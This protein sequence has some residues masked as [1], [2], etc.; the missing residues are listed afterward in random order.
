MFHFFT[1]VIHKLESLSAFLLFFFLHFFFFLVVNIYHFSE[2]FTH[3]QRNLEQVSNKVPNYVK[4][5]TKHFLWRLWKNEKMV[6][7]YITFAL[8]AFA[9]PSYAEVGGHDLF[10][11]LAQLEVLWRNEMKVV[12]VMQDTLQKLDE[13]KATLNA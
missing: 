4:L 10:T 9:K 3:D 2:Q 1:I 5:I 13:A 7:F 12:Q 11:S 6:K 8:L